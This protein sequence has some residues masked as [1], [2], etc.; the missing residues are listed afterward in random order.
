MKLDWHY[1]DLPPSDPYKKYL[2]IYAPWDRNYNANTNPRYTIADYY[3]GNE[4]GLIY[5]DKP[6]HFDMCYSAERRE[7][8]AWAELDDREEVLEERK[9]RM[10]LQE[11]EA[12]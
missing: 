12:K 10:K 2:V 4:P 5:N 8:L 9:S 7:I 11:G 3:P 1:T 6:W